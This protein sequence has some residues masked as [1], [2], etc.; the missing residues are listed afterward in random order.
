MKS[1]RVSDKVGN[2]RNNWAEL[3]EPIL[4]YTPKH[5]KKTKGAK[6]KKEPP[7]RG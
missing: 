3:V 4:D 1:W 6:S 2:Y 5:E 7:L